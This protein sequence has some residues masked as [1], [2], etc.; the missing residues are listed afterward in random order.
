MTPADQHGTYRAMTDSP[1]LTP[2][3]PPAITRLSQ[4]APPVNDAAT[5][6]NGD[7]RA[8]LLAKIQERL[9]DQAVTSELEVGTLQALLA[10]LNGDVSLTS[11][12]SESKHQRRLNSTPLG[13]SVARQMKAQPAP[14]PAGDM[15]PARRAKLLGGSSLGAALM[16]AA[17]KKDLR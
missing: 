5:T 11:A 13:A 15:D 1:K 12:Y 9:S 17:R 2:Y 4:N 8:A 16:Q 6:P 10:A 14:A 3:T 7:D